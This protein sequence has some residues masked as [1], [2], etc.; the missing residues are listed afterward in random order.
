MIFLRFS[1]FYKA[2]YIYVSEAHGVKDRENGFT[3]LEFAVLFG[4]KRDVVL[5]FLFI[6]RTKITAQNS[7]FF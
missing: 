1:C 4:S 7:S 3:N 2:R 6:L 5:R